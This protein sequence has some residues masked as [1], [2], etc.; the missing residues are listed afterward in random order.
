MMYRF[1]HDPESGAIYVRLR[2]GTYRETIPLGDPGLGAGVD[3]DDEGYVLGVEFLSFEEYA[4]VVAARG[5]RLE[6]PERV[7]EI[8]NLVGYFHV[9]E[10]RDHPGE[11]LWEFRSAE[12]GVAWVRSSHRYRDRE[13]LERSINCFRSSPFGAEVEHLSPH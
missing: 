3:V 7:E 5:G 12:S 1:T 11:H 8:D 6:L 9:Y 2:E 10:D 4:E 13:A